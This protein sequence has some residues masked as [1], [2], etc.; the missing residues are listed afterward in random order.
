M[1]SALLV[2][3]KDGDFA[4]GTG[5]VALARSLA[6]CGEGCCT[7]ARES[8]FTTPPWPEGLAANVLL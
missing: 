1:R 6:S 8:R 5:P 7:V 4:V 3:E 2:L